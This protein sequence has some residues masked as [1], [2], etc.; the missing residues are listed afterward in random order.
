MFP[1]GSQSFLKDL[2]YPW[3]WRVYSVF[4]K[5]SQWDSAA[6]CWLTDEQPAVS[7]VIDLYDATQCIDYRSDSDRTETGDQ[8]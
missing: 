3:T 6:S 8:N 7:S 5:D 4:L 2:L 1:Q